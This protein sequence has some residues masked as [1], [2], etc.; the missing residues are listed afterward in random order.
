MRYLR[1]RGLRSLGDTG[2]ITVAPI[3]V[4]LGENSSGKSTFLRTFPL[5]RQS[6]EVRTSEPLLWF[7]R[8]VDFGTFEESVSS[9]NTDK[10]VEIDVSLDLDPGFSGSNDAGFFDSEPQGAPCS[11]QFK[12]SA[13]AQAPGAPGLIKIASHVS[14]LI[15][16]ICET[17]IL[18]QFDSP[19]V[20]SKVEIDGEDLTK[21]AQASYGVAKSVSPTP[22]LYS[23]NRA[24]DTPE[25]EFGPNVRACNEEIHEC[26]KGLVHGRTK[27]DS[28][29]E[30]IARIRLG[31]PEEMLTAIQESQ[32]QKGFWKRFVLDWTVE[33]AEFVRYR[34]LLWGSRLEEILDSVERSIKREF[35]S[36][37]YITP[38]RAAAERYYRQQGLDRKSVV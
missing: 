20:L 24:L 31:T 3:T 12:I 22:T 19:A 17:K 11:V 37:S 8:L 10:S 35:G 21:M 1:V 14:Q 16:D 23:L 2:P 38:L 36:I 9:F 32:S 6:V 28:I 15:L 29:D 33:T 18:L 7:G 30:L 4:L 26:V 13:S 34:R 27:D 5:L 25:L